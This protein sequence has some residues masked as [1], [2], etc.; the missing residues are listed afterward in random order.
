MSKYVHPLQADRR[1]PERFSLGAASFTALWAYAEGMKI[2]GGR[3]YVFDSALMF[4]SAL[5]Y[6]LLTR[7]LSD[8]LALGV[9][10]CLFFAGRITI[11][12]LAPRY[13]RQHLGLLGYR[14][15]R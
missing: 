4:A 11:G 1:S 15:A 6:G 3:L 12:F 10:V 9:G 5:A 13:L 7:L 14:L 2:L 8:A